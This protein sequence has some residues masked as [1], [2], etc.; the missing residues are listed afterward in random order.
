MGETWTGLCRARNKEKSDLLIPFAGIDPFPT[1]ERSVYEKIL[2]LSSSPG[3]DFGRTSGRKM[4]IRASITPANAVVNQKSDLISM[5][6]R[7]HK[8]T[9]KEEELTATQTPEPRDPLLEVQGM[10][11]A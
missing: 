1:M 7:L 9:V 3:I 11:L 10:D 6:Q 5:C 8:L 2:E 4:I